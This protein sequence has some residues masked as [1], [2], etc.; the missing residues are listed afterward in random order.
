MARHRI[1][2]IPLFRNL[3]VGTG[4]TC[5]S[6]PIDLRDISRIG[7]YSISYRVGPAGAS[8]TAGTATFA[9]LGSPVFDGTY[10]LESGTSG[11]SL[12][13]AT[14]GTGIWQLSPF[15]T[16]FMKIRGVMGTSGTAIISA[17]L[18]VQ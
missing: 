15:L 12:S 14:G 3:T 10:V 4:G 13:S 11:T 9:Y 6:D 5:L 18:N 7:N 1:T 8:A 17:E 2:T 16:P